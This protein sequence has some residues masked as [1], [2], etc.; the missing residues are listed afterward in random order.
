MSLT[1]ASSMAPRLCCGRGVHGAVCGLE[2]DPARGE[3]EVSYFV[4]MRHAAGLE[5]IE[6]TIAA[7]SLQLR[8]YQYPG[9]HQRGDQRLGFLERVFGRGEAGEQRRDGAGFQEVDDAREH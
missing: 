8:C 2:F 9:V 4:R 5:H 3:M 6:L 1:S 7:P